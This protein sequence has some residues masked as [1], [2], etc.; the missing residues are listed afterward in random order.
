M[1]DDGSLDVNP[2]SAAPDAAPVVRA[3]HREGTLARIVE[4]QT[5]KIPSHVFLLAS[6]VAMGVSLTAELEGRQR[7]SRF[8]GMWVAPLLIMGVYNKMVKILGTR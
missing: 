8:V 1:A 7:T 2:A 3:E 4:Q 5:A 6:L